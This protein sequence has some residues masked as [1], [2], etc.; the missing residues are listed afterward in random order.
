VS[1]GNRRDIAGPIG[2]FVA[3][4]WSRKKM[5]ERSGPSKPIIGRIWKGFGLKPPLTDG[6]KLSNGPIHVH[7][8]GC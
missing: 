8:T 4:H 3:T 2:S 6:F 5:G 7:I 1:R